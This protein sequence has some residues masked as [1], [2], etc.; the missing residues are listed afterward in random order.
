MAVLS[1]NFY[2]IVRFVR[3]AEK[4][5]FGTPPSITIPGD[6]V[7]NQLMLCDTPLDTQQQAP[8]LNPPIITH[9]AATPMP[10][11]QV[12]VTRDG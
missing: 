10:T 6:D 9:T 4:K 8:P 3:G 7:N 11:P 12:G 5:L 2:V 1:S